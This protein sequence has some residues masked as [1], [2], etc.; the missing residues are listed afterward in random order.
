LNSLL[1]QDLGHIDRM[2]LPVQDDCDRE[3]DR[4]GITTGPE[5]LT[6]ITGGVL[7]NPVFTG[8][9]LGLLA[10]SAQFVISSPALRPFALRGRA[11][12]R[13]LS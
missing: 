5:L 13:R 4:A 8:I 7:P 2:D 6:H 12:A 1:V 10:R 11:E 3:F 9:I